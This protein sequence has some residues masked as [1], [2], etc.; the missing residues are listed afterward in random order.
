MKVSTA[1]SCTDEV[2]QVVTDVIDGWYP[3]G[4]IDWEDVWGRVDGSELPDGSLIDMGDLLDTPATRRIKR[5][6]R[7]QRED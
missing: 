4:R 2:M 5:F 6:V 1:E 7:A 3:E